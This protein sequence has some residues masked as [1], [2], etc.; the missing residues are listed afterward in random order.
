MPMIL[1][2]AKIIAELDA[3]RV[4]DSLSALPNQID[5]ALREAPRVKFAAAYKKSS[6]IVVAG[7][8]G[9]TLGAHLVKSVYGN[10]MSVPFCFI[11][12]YRLPG[13]VGKN[14]V[15]I[16]SSYSGT[17]EETLSCFNEAKA[18]GAKI[19]GIASGGPLAAKL[20]KAKAPAYIFSPKFN[21]GNQPRMGLGYMF[22]GLV[23]FL[24]S[25][26]KIPTKALAELAV[27]GLYVRQTSKNWE[28]ETPGA[29]NSAKI[30]ARELAEK[31]PIIVSAEH[32]V[33]N[34]HILQNQIHEGPKQFCAA[35]P[36]PELN[37]HLMEGLQFPKTASSEL[38]FLF[39][40]SDLYSKK[41]AK[42][43]SIT[44]KVVAKQ[45]FQHINWQPNSKTKIGQA[46]E[47]LSFGG[48]MSFYMAMEN[49]VNPSFIPWVN[50]FKKELKQ[51]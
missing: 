18:R 30:L 44:E 43:V 12:D 37:H 21:P 4:R 14:S 39:L 3:G 16:L 50:F 22:A 2:D 27:A 51:G 13:S 28:M 48:W 38:V 23:S 33:A 6:E 24:V 11:N 49:R 5:A 7:M 34:A 32:L 31:I 35:F 1:D 41:L 8:G 19:C 15:V 29:V 40:N 17:T 45:N 36:L 25:M 20:K 46:L 47:T 10:S 42:R 9:S 26:N